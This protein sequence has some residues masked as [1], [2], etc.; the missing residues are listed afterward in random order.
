M[1]IK[2]KDGFFLSETMI[3]I[4]IVATVLLIVF[5]LFTSVY[6]G[7]VES[8]NYNTVTAINALANI[9]KYFE[10]I[11]KIDITGLSETNPYVNLTNDSKYESN[12]FT[13]IKE[14]YNVT[15]IYL[16][17]LNFLYASDYSNEFYA[18]LRRY[19]K[20]FERKSGIIMVVAIDK[21]EFAYTN[22]VD[23]T[24]VTLVGDKEDEYG[25]YVNVG[26]EFVDPGYEGWTGEEP[27]I[28]WENG[29]VVDTS[30]PG[31]YYLH[32]DFDGYLFRRKVVVDDFETN[33]GYVGGYQTYEALYDGYYKI[34]LMGAKGASGGNGGYSSGVIKLNS[35]DKIYIYVGGEADE[36]IAGYNGGGYTNINADTGYGGKGG[37]GAT[38][39]RYFASVTPSA[40]DLLWNSTLGLN[41][42]IMVAGGGGGAE[43]TGSVGGKGGGLIASKGIGV[44]NYDDSTPN[45]TYVAYGGA[46]TYGGSAYAYNGISWAGGFG[47]GG[48]TTDAIDSGGMG[49]GG[50]YGGG[51][52]NVA[53][54]GGG[55]SSFIS[56]YAGVNAITSSTDRTHTNNTLHYSNK[57][58]LNG[59]MESGVNSGAGTAKITYIGTSYNKTTSK[60]NEARY[61]K[62]CINGNSVNTYNH[63]LELQAISNGTNVAYGKTVTSTSEPRAGYG[64]QLS[65]LVDGNFEYNN[66]D[67]EAGNQCVT[68]DLGDLYDLDEIAVWHHY[69]DQR[70]YNNHSLYVS[71]DNTNW[72]TLIDNVSGVTETSQ[73]IRVSA[74]E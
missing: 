44:N 12:Y 2:N 60:M 20:T 21:T 40:A 41:S 16:I 39:I 57:Y 50:Y 1:R 32:Y 26:G 74:Y 34:E 3:V 23:Y 27:T 46:Q 31:T 55:G 52:M 49:G 13:R 6:Y 59:K 22:I 51:S 19:I 5:K 30:T 4:S 67:L 37:G 48:Y 42:R 8:E 28:S 66:V 18:T 24:N 15:E 43:W 33:F 14:E 54:G 72:T 38:D 70:S 62:D 64:A 73:G 53:H 58:F 11:D 69:E 63:W 36:N 17:D 56:G 47:Y 45:T 29:E 71:S 35:K 61:I 7:F 68:V 10:S 25:V 65:A 9:Q